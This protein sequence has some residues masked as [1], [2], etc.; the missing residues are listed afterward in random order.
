MTYIRGG[1]KGELIVASAYLLYDSDK[2]PPSKMFKGSLQL[3]Q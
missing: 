2:P 1:S 3:L